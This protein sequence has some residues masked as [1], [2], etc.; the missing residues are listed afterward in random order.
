VKEINAKQEKQCKHLPSRRQTKRLQRKGS[1]RQRP[2]MGLMGQMP[3]SRSRK[4]GQP[5]TE[6]NVYIYINI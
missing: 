6:T 4:A 2:L 1:Q 5:R 3:V